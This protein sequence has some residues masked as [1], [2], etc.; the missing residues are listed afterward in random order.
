MKEGFR[1][2]A[3][4]AALVFSMAGCATAPADRDIPAPAPAPV[5]EPE[6]P[7]IRDDA[8]VT[9]VVKKGDTL[10]D[11]A[12]TFLTSPWRWPEVWHINPQVRNPHLIYP[13]DV[14]TL[15]YVDGK[16]VVQVQDG[17]AGVPPTTLP[18]VKLSPRVRVEPLER[19]IPTIP[20]DAISQFLSRPRV[21]TPEE[22]RRAPYMISAQEEHLIGGPGYPVYVRGLNGGDVKDFVVVRLGEPYLNPED[23]DDVLGYEAIHVADARLQRQ[24]DPATVMLVRAKREALTGD[25]L[26]PAD[27]GMLEQNY[28]PHPPVAEVEGRIVGV[29][30]AVSQIGQF[31]VV[32]ISK[33]VRD[34]M[35]PGHVLAIYQAGGLVRDPYTREEVRLPRERAGTLMVFRVFDRVSYALVMDA[36]RAIHLH[37][38]VTNP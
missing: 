31:Q 23:P 14:L 38:V 4:I 13:G 5:A 17:V 12:T 30:G 25:R 33:G 26:L 20:Y 16:P 3:W 21:V 29:M 22:L 36:T 8:P 1:S 2:V 32:A 18:T 9:Y 28:L 24:G 34:D 15:T 11:I 19:A 27:D 10:W 35:E 7:V 6:P 37:D